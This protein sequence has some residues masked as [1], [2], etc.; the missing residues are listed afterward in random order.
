MSTV[1]R[2]PLGRRGPRVEPLAAV[3][4]ATVRAGGRA[5]LDAVDLE[6]R[7]GE[8]L[9]VVGPNGAGKTTL[10]SVLAGDLSPDAGA[11]TVAGRP[12]DQWR[13]VELARRR[14]V[15]PQQN[16]L[17]FPFTVGEVVAMGRA[18]WRGTESQDRDEEIVAAVLAETDVAELAG[19]RYPTLSGGEQ[20][21]VAL[22]RVLAQDTELLLL[23]EPTASLDLR[24]QEDV[25]RLVGARAASGAGVVLVLHDLT[26]A[27]AFAD[28]IAVLDEGKLAAVGPPDQVC[29]AELLSEVY[30]CAVEIVSHPGS[31][32]PIVLPRRD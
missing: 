7:A 25:L 20:A 8:V 10:L 12:A 32:K 24:H 9:A 28:R 26:L 23:D 5:L 18:P 3:R 13:T 6:A 15:L 2:L 17:S 16:P 19:R 4:Q 22:A 21:R 11:A 1:V 31:G 27:A 14:A 30:R 29:T